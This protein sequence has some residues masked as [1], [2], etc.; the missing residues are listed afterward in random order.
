MGDTAYG[1]YAI[2]YVV[3]GYFGFL[4]MGLG[5]ASVKY[6]AE[7]A[8]AN[9]KEEIESVFGTSFI[10]SLI[11]GFIGAF[12]IYLFTP[13][14]ISKYIKIPLELQPLAKN[15]FF[16]G[17]IGF[18][19]NMLMSVPNALITGFQRLDIANKIGMF[20]GTMERLVAVSVLFI[21]LGL[22]E[23]ILGN[24]LIGVITFFILWRISRNFIS[25]RKLKFDKHTFI[26]LFAFGGYVTISGIVGP[27]LTDIEKVLIGYFISV[28]F[29]P[30][31]VIPYNLI[32]HLGI[33]PGAVTRALFPAISSWSVSDKKRAVA[34]IIKSIRYQTAI[35]L[36]VVIF[37]FVLTPDF[38]NLWI[39]REFSMKATNPMRI[40]IIAIIINFIAHP[41]FVFLQAIGKPQIP[42]IFHLLELP[43]HIFFC[44]CFIK[45]WQIDGAAF[46][47]L[48]RVILDTS[49]LVFFFKK[50]AGLLSKELFLSFI[51]LST[52]I[53]VLMGILLWLIKVY[54]SL[55]FIIIYVLL[56]GVIYLLFIWNFLLPEEERESIKE[57]ISSLLSIKNSL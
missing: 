45:R 56:S 18:V 48:L 23:V 13:T 43:L 40:L 38:L 5:S 19:L 12:L 1:I 24:L 26:N 55:P 42:A 10:S 33:I 7:Y 27:I 8:S 4:Q 36:P 22:L 52:I 47:W 46:A 49:F 9:K 20:R 14:L 17:A 51:N 39:G 2:L 50:E 34:N 32:M 29:I 37:L 31:Y 25:L 15:A 44:V 54:F 53:S 11:M 41:P 57:T 16:I 28:S 21:G 3:I 30:Y 6:I 35:L